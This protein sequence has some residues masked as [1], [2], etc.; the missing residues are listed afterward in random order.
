MNNLATTV[1]Q[2]NGLKIQISPDLPKMQLSED[3]PVS[4]EFRADINDWMKQFFGYSNIIEDGQIL[5]T[6]AEQQQLLIMNPRTYALF[7]TLG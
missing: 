4:D 1:Q 3:C 5:T 6:F 2:F 7:K